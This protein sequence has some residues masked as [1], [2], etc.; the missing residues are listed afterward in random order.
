MK[1]KN[2]DFGINGLSALNGF[3]AR[4]PDPHFRE[5]ALNLSNEPPKKRCSQDCSDE[6]ATFQIRFFGQRACAVSVPSI[7]IRCKPI[8]YTHCLATGEGWVNM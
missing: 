6:E 4:L 7:Q 1:A 8:S 2:C 5:Q 3:P